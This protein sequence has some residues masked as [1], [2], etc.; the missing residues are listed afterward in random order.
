M[1][2]EAGTE[3]S[4][5]VLVVDMA[6]VVGSVPDGWWRDRAGAAGRLLS[7]LAGLLGREVED[8]DGRRTT[9]ERIVAVLE[10]RAKQAGTPEPADHR[11]MVVR[12]DGSGDDAI[13]RVSIELV[14]AGARVLVVTA[15]RGLCA[16]LP[17]AVITIGPGWLNRLLGRAKED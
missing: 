4:A 3:P 1:V 16:R 12:A 2:T 11:L 7:A 10:G 14:T 8:P 13:A 17:A 15:D 5:T 6:N 9:L